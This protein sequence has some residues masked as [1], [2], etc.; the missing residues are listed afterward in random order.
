VAAAYALF[1]TDA[2]A[3]TLTPDYSSLGT[4]YQDATGNL[5]SSAA[6]D[7]TDVTALM[8]TDISA[9]FTYLQNAILLPWTETVTFKIY[10]LGPITVA[11]SGIDTVTSDAAKRPKTSTVTYTVHSGFP[12]FIDPT[13]FDNSEFTM[14]TGTAALGGGTENN[15]RFGNA[16]A[17]GGAKDK[18]DFLTLTLHEVEH[19]LGIS[20]G[21]GSGFTRFL[22]LVGASNSTTDRKL[23][24]PK[25]LSGLP[26]DFDIPIVKNTSHFI[27]DPTNN[28]TFGFAVV[29]D[30]GWS[31]SQRAL[32]TCLD[33]LAI[34]RVEGATANQIYCETLVPE[35]GTIVL[36]GI[37]FMAGAGYRRR[38]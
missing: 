28:D 37:A 27:G 18:W 1:V 26:N 35:P 15:K 32:P 30:P 24:I 22:D 2:A 14:S 5:Y 38:R 10:D 21:Q 33:I 13:P 20:N 34:G 31:L 3:V 9:A 6:A 12:M 36:V 4:V 16:T 7:R 8:K 23:T 19:S 29:S 25:A 17:G 11:N